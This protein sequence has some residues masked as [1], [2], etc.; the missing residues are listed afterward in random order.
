MN[1]PPIGNRSADESANHYILTRASILQTCRDTF[2]MEVIPEQVHEGRCPQCSI[3]MR[4]DEIYCPE[5]CFRLGHA[6]NVNSITV[7]APPLMYN[8]TP[9]NTISRRSR[10]YHCA[11][12]NRRLCGYQC[13]SN[14]TPYRSRPNFHSPLTSSPDIVRCN[15]CTTPY[16]YGNCTMVHEIPTT[17]E[18][19]IEDSYDTITS[20]RVHALP[21]LALPLDYY[22]TETY[23]NQNILQNEDHDDMHGFGYISPLSDHYTG[24]RIEVVL[25]ST[26]RSRVLFSY[27]RNARI[28][29][30]SVKHSIIRYLLTLRNALV[31]AITGGFVIYHSLPLRIAY[32]REPALNRQT[33][34]RPL[35]L[36]RSRNTGRIMI[37]VRTSNTND[38]ENLALRQNRP[39][40]IPRFNFIPANDNP[41]FESA[42]NNEVES[43]QPRTRPTNEQL[44]EASP[45]AICREELHEGEDVVRLPG[46]GHIFHYVGCLRL[47]LAQQRQCPICRQRIYMED[48]C[49]TIET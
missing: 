41:T 16:H 49:N 6:A 18:I 23:A 20:Q 46:C 1:S 45:C 47:W 43:L 27:D 9:S 12:C 42:I 26:T 36:R 28:P 30:A 40:E 19:E 37:G 3:P 32:T 13:P 31:L 22:C 10:S 21:I 39:V 25:N 48:L 34:E 17:N 7:S 29:S 11:T 4:T 14:T 5:G 2:G 15:Q 33:M 38:N 44:F 8:L 35:E 24:V